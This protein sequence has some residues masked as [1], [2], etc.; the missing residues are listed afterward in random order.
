[1]NEEETELHTFNICGRA[2]DKHRE[3][4][5]LTDLEVAAGAYGCMDL[6]FKLQRLGPRYAMVAQDLLLKGQE[7]ERIERV[8]N[9]QSSSR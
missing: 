1:M 9:D 3:G 5:A 4:E 7:F 2:I 6:S 8:R